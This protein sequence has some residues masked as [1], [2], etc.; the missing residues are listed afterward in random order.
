MKV[1][2]SSLIPLKSETLRWDIV[3]IFRYVSSW[4]EE[5]IPILRCFPG[6]LPISVHSGWVP[7]GS[8]GRPRIASWILISLVWLWSRIF[9][10]LPMWLWCIQ[11]LEDEVRI[12]FSPLWASWWH[13]GWLDKAAGRWWY[14]GFFWGGGFS[15]GSEPLPVWLLYY[16][17]SPKHCGGVTPEHRV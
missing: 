10:W 4:P 9:T 7:R 15:L 2:L 5:I 11:T 17:W 16:I 1:W 13:C 12:L 6:L 14:P 8:K 3:H